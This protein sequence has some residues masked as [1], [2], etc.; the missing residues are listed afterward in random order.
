MTDYSTCYPKIALTHRQTAPNPGR[1]RLRFNTLCNRIGVALVLF[2]CGT[3]SADATYYARYNDH[4]GFP[5]LPNTIAY[6]TSWRLAGAG[7]FARI[8][9]IM[10]QAV[11]PVTSLCHI[12]CF[13][14]HSRQIVVIRNSCTSIRAIPNCELTSITMNP[15]F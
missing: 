10:V 1:S 7:M 12:L 13:E 4:R 5:A 15:K 6:I 2:R 9:L 8:A 3:C 11:S 14:S